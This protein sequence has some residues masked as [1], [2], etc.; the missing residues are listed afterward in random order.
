MDGLVIAPY[1]TK[2]GIRVTEASF[3]QKI[4]VILGHQ[5]WLVTD[6]EQVDQLLSVRTQSSTQRGRKHYNL[7]YHGSSLLHRDLAEASFIEALNDHLSQIV[8]ATAKTALIVAGFLFESESLRYLVPTHS[9]LSTAARQRLASLDCRQIENRSIGI[10]ASGQMLTG[11]KIMNDRPFQLFVDTEH[12]DTFLSRGSLVA[13]LLA[14]GLNGD[15]NPGLALLAAR[16]LVLNSQWP[17]VRL[18]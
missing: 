15:P 10:L 13:L 8:E 7:L 2:I 9:A 6:H 12:P 11:G 1:G 18:V 17:P 5:G 3:K 14:H 4:K 16:N